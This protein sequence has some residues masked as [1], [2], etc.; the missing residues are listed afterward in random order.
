VFALGFTNGAYAV[1]AIGSMM[2]LAASGRNSSEGVRMGVW[3]AAQAVAFGI[4]GFSGTAAVD[5][6]RKL[7][8]VPATA[9]ATVFI[10]EATLFLLAAMLALRSIASKPAVEQ[11]NARLAPRGRLAMEAS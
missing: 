9:Y 4:G 1:A 10:F 2:G 8:D 11:S 7:V 6:M 5:I 3:G